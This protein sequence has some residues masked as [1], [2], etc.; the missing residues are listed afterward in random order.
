MNYEVVPV[1]GVHD[2]FTKHFPDWRA[3]DC[4]GFRSLPDS[5]MMQVGLIKQVRLLRVAVV[6]LQRSICKIP[7]TTTAT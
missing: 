2:R 5:R 4:V 1:Q 3:G 6:V 7:E